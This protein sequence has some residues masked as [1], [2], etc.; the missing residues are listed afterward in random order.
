MGKQL[1]GMRKLQKEK[2]T[3]NSLVVVML[4]FLS[5]TISLPATAQREEN[6]S[7]VNSTPVNTIKPVSGTPV[8]TMADETI[9][10]NFSS[11]PDRHDL[12]TETTRLTPNYSFPSLNTAM[13]FNDTLLYAN[14]TINIYDDLSFNISNTLADETVFENGFS[15]PSFTSYDYQEGSF[16]I[17]NL[18]SYYTNWTIEGGSI[19]DYYST[20][21]DDDS[22]YIASSF[23]I[24]KATNIS[25]INLEIQSKG[26]SVAEV[27]IT[28]V[29]DGKPN[30][31]VY[32]EK[33]SLTTESGSITLTYSQPVTLLEGTYALVFKDLTPALDGNY[34]RV[35]TVD[36]LENGNQSRTWSYTYDGSD[37]TTEQVDLIFSF[38]CLNVNSSDSSLLLEYLPEEVNFQYNG[39]EIT[40]LDNV[41][42]LN[43]TYNLFSSNCSISFDL[44][45]SIDYFFLNQ[46]QLGLW[47]AFSNQSTIESQ[48][49]LSQQA[50]IAYPASPSYSLDRVI[51]LQGLSPDWN[52]SLILK[53]SSLFSDA[54]D[55]DPRINYSNG[56][57]DL[58]VSSGDTTAD[59]FIWDFFFSAPNY[60]ASLSILRDDQLTWP[61]QANNTDILDFQAELIEDLSIGNAS[62]I[63]NN[64]Q[65]FY[66]QNV[67]PTNGFL[68][69][70]SWDIASSLNSTHDVNGTYSIIFMFIDTINFKLGY[71]KLLLEIIVQT[72]LATPESL[73]SLI[74]E[75]ADLSVKYSSFLNE[76]S[77]DGANITYASSWGEIGNLT[78]TSSHSNYSCLIS[79]APSAGEW[80][81]IISALLPGHVSR[82]ANF[83]LHYFYNSS[84]TYTI[85]SSS[86]Y[87]KDV[88][89]IE[90][91]YIDNNNDSI[92]GAT[93]T[94]N[95]SLF[96]LID[97]GSSYLVYYNTSH[98]DPSIVN[99]KLIIE[100][101]KELYLPMEV[102]VSFEQKANPTTINPSSLTP[103]NQSSI[104]RYVTSSSADLITLS[105]VYYDTN[106]GNII[107][108]TV[109]SLAQTPETVS[110]EYEVLLN[111]SVIVNLDPH[112]VGENTIHISFSKPG[113]QTTLYSLALETI[114]S[115]T[116]IRISSQ[117]S[118][119]LTL[120]NSSSVNTTYLEGETTELIF[121]VTYFDI[122]HNEVIRSVCN[123]TPSNESFTITT[124]EFVNGTWRVKVTLLATGDYPLVF[125]FFEEN[126]N[127]VEFMVDLIVEEGSSPTIQDPSDNGIFS[128]G[129][130]IMGII[131]TLL[132]LALMYYGYK[133]YIYLTK[134]TFGNA[135][136][137]AMFIQETS[138]VTLYSRPLTRQFEADPLLISGFISAIN[139]F[140]QEIF[141]E[142][143][144]LE[145]IKHG[146][147]TIIIE[148]KGKLI[149]AL[150]V[151]KE[152]PEVRALL[153]SC[154]DKIRITTNGFLVDVYQL[155]DEINPYVEASF[156]TNN[157]TNWSL[158]TENLRKWLRNLRAKFKKE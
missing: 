64:S 149:F 140:G 92:T 19:T 115:E 6:N 79:S 89:V 28:G 156:L 145:T 154:C 17:S 127:S 4:L 116:T 143:G 87:Y 139:Q 51:S 77:L 135:N 49:F 122:T 90:L 12:T 13:D 88:I 101:S 46:T 111:G 118:L 59:S 32:G 106:H 94:I 148:P 45:Y 150:I 141:S 47:C 43:V 39:T 75:S 42:M 25:T 100:L 30:S 152:T 105:F 34:Y 44:S 78:Q 107:N 14:E 20:R 153:R 123:T 102:S 35:G 96:E 65:V 8:T 155:Q 73:T 58:I 112:T 15:T 147:N 3:L 36:D 129:F 119:G 158:F 80:F 97:D 124:S 136:P 7:L 11:D 126:Y 93:G 110:F 57:N 109:V 91:H 60:L 104:Q 142:S 5:L 81:V 157:K 121:L 146:D 16:S 84:L 63:V 22:E 125:S 69:F 131:L 26:S 27:Y 33:I 61:Y 54:I 128:L 55:S 113:Y 85:N 82:S 41:S 38:T 21:Y 31:T 56:S 2:A 144:T 137:K 99:F 1:M 23:V 67:T 70:D 53:D 66:Y 83:S 62:L 40:Q 108:G 133:L 9:I 74:G 95:N 50:I 68:D 103:L 98:N 132:I 151:E 24:D 29:T 10:E 117:S 48:L 71:Q 18:R 37:W 120:E 76:T 130:L 134:D 52:A 138:G 72:T 114:P 86:F